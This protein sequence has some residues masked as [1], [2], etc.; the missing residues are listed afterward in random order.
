MREGEQPVIDE[1]QRFTPLWMRTRN[2]PGDPI[3]IAGTMLKQAGMRLRIQEEDEGQFALIFAKSPVEKESLI[4]LMRRR[5]MQLLREAS[6]GRGV[7]RH[8]FERNLRE[9]PE[10]QWS[11][12]DKNRIYIHFLNKSALQLLALSSLSHSRKQEEEA[13]RYEERAAQLARD[14]AARNRN[15]SGLLSDTEMTKY[16]SGV[17]EKHLTDHPYQLL[18]PL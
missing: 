15:G 10:D 17:V 5:D 6:E 7:H 13:K 1:R 9:I 18:F 3:L 12:T 16:V 2:E 14:A 11:D 8:D 4:T